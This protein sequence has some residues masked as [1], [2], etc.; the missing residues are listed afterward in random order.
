MEKNYRFGLALILGLLFPSLLS[1]Q[2]TPEVGYY[3]FGQYRYFGPK[4]AV[5]K[6]SN[7]I[8]GSADSAK[9]FYNTLSKPQFNFFKNTGRTFKD[10]MGYGDWEKPYRV[11]SGFEYDFRQSKNSSSSYGYND[12]S[13]TFFLLG[14]KAF[15]NNYWRFGA[16][17]ALSRYNT[18]YHNAMKL[19]QDNSLAMFYAIY[20]DAPRQ[21]R[22]RSRAYLGYGQADF[23]RLAQN[24]TSVQA[25]RD[26]FHTYYYGFENALSKTFSYNNFYLQPTVEFNGWG[27]DRSKVSEN[28]GAALQLKPRS[29]FLLDGLVG[30]YAGYKGKDTWGN[31]YNIKVGPDLTHVFSDPND[32][33]ELYSE[34]DSINMKKRPDKKDYITWKA[35]LNYDFTNGVGI[36]SDL[37]YYKKDKDS[38]AMA[39]GLNYRF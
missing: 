25:F 18:E 23:L 37:R 19:D 30:L 14:D 36:Y 17:L 22:L 11:M 26:D 4:L 5:D 20:N 15:A 12:K 3:L 33:F 8:G 16:G 38:I 6:T 29:P 21:I 27:L 9:R 13:G 7:E 32:A 2:S 24:G 34:A 35:Y 39:L 31:K 28:G 10:A 1:A